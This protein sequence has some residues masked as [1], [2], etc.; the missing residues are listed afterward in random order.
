MILCVLVLSII[1]VGCVNAATPQITAINWSVNR[2]NNLRVVLDCTQ[3]TSAKAELTD[4]TLT[5]TINGKLK[6][7][8][9]RRYSFA[10]STVKSMNLV[11]KGDKTILIL[12]LKRPL[13]SSEY[14]L[15]V[16]KN[17]PGANRPDRVVL[18]V[19]NGEVTAGEQKNGGA[20]SC[21][22]PTYSVAGGIRGKHITLDP[23]HGGSDPGAHGSVTGVEEKSI[24]LPVAKKLKAI[25]EN[26]GV[27]VSM[28]RTTDVD[29][30]GSD[31][32][33]AQELQARVDVAEK[34]K[35]DLFISV[36]CNANTNKSIGGFSTYY[37]PKTS[38]D[39]KIADCIQ[40]SLLK[41]GNLRDLGTRA[42]NLY[43]NKHCS[44]PGALVELLFLSNEREEKLLR[45]NW[46]QNKMA[47]AI[48]D[49]I[50]D[51]YKQNGGVS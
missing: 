32:T 5:I 44:M 1:G 12:P 19:V 36:H 16:L 20:A 42:A 7:S 45:S 41:T 28:T 2:E 49:G 6:P 48:A 25:L 11:D 29:V 18:D 27:I 51:F 50:E 34:N 38:Y 23:G 43:V 31:A 46:F 35:A 17:N 15:F 39:D 33:D 10:S 21:I 4:A 3:L 40:N 8:I 9:G 14:K 24:T 37:N 13:K 26:K 22:V 47:Q 30:W